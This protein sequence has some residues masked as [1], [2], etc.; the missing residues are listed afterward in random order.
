MLTFDGKHARGKKITYKG[1]QEHLQEKYGCEIGYGT[2]VQLCVIRSKR[3]I[4]ARR[5]KGVAKVTCRKARKGFAVKLNPDAH[6]SSSFYK[7]LDFV[8]LK[9][10]KNKVLLNRDDQARFRLDATF[11]H[12]QGK[13]ITLENTPALTTRTDFVNS[14]P[15]LL[16]TT[17]YL[18]ME[19][20]TTAKACVGVVKPHF[21]FPKSPTK[22]AIDLE[23]LEGKVPGHFNHRQIECIRVDGAADEGPSHTEDQF[24][25]TERHIMKKTICTV[26]SSRHSGGSYLN[27]VELMNGCIAK[28]H[29]NL[30][31]PSTLTGSTFD[32]NGLNKGK[33][34]TNLDI[35]TDIYIDRVNG[36]PCCG[37]HLQLYKGARNEEMTERRQCLLIFLKGN[38]K[39]KKRLR[40]KEP[41][42]FRYFEN[43]WRVRA[44]HMNRNV[45]ENYVFMLTLCHQKECTHPLC[46]Q[47]TMK[48]DTKWFENGLPLTYLPVPIPDPERPWGG[49]CQACLNICTGHYLEPQQHAEFIK[50]KGLTQSMFKPPSA[51]IK[52]EYYESVKE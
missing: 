3:S 37:R 16:Q 5:Y 43:V 7:G 36:A 39:D 50:E 34:S 28:A 33:L 20:E 2:V 42:L 44:S 31:I 35:A 51:I 14:Y 10:G 19:S 38:S 22:H 18:F 46:G 40:E 6:W 21:P 11:T 24:L 29:A 25:W 23:M 49:E 47:E 27:E 13:C 41:D 45:P 12:K 15:S 26:V 17:S 30:Y 48:G 8:Q 52:E 32:A 4:S 1:I 9:D